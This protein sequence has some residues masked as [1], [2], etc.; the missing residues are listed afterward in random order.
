MNQNSEHGGVVENQARTEANNGQT[1]GCDYKAFKNA[2]P[3]TFEAKDGPITAMNWLDDMEICFQTCQCAPLTDQEQINQCHKEYPFNLISMLKARKY[4]LK[5]C[6]TYLAY[7]VD[8][9]KEKKGVE[10]VSIVCEYLEVFLDDLP[11]LPPDRQ[12]EFHIDLVCAA[13]PIARTPYRLA[14]TE[15]QELMSQ[16]QELLDKGF[17][18]PSSSPWGALVLFVRKKDETMRMCIDYRELNK[19]TIKNIYPLPKIDDLF[20]QLQGA[21]YFSQIDLC[22]GYHQLKVQKEDIP[23]T[24]FQTRYGHYEFLVMPF[25]LTNAPVVFMDLINRQF[26]LTKKAN[27]FEWGSSQEKAFRTLKDKLS[28]ALILC[29]SEGVEDFVIHS[30]ASK[31]GLGCMLMQRNKVIA[32]ASRQLRTHETNYPI[33]DLELA[34]VVFAL[35]IWRHYLYGTKC[36]LYTEHRSLKYIF[37]QKE[38]NIRQRRWMELLKDYDCKSN[39][40]QGK[41]MLWQTPKVEKKLLR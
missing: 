17:I 24:A 11:G 12:V 21:S 36:I 19:V 34:A 8:V 7:M 27:K 35:K 37:D 10:E 33:H 39:I 1:H 29:L 41:P 20:D 13:V 18:R 40:I 4:I 28:S 25:G 16:L 23:K 22:S 2:S 38:L 30:D 32:F 9:K 3:S 14:P 15:M 31:Q 6:E 5:G 26:P